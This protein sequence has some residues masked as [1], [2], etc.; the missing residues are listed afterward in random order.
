MPCGFFPQ[1][2]PHLYVFAVMHFMAFDTTFHLLPF[3]ATNIGHTK[4]HGLCHKQWIYQTTCWHSYTGTTACTKPCAHT[5]PINF[6][7]IPQKDTMTPYMAQLRYPLNSQVLAIFFLSLT[8]PATPH[9]PEFTDRYS[10]QY[11]RLS[12]S[13][14]YMINTPFY[15]PSPTST[16]FLNP[17]TTQD[18]CTPPSL[19]P[20][21]DFQ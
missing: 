5:R 15:F 18:L 16:Y 17:K 10:P 9:Y 11:G 1:P 12:F 20:L 14:H 2:I 13:L 8:T 19:T 6:N 4:P 3:C 7:I 21:T